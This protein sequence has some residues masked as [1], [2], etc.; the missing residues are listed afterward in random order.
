MS[1][2]AVESRRTD[3]GEAVA[4]D[5]FGAAAPV[6][7]KLLGRRP[8][9]PV[10]SRLRRASSSLPMQARAAASACAMRALARQA[11]SSSTSLRRRSVYRCTNGRRAAKEEGELA[12]EVSITDLGFPPDTALAAGSR[13]C[14]SM[15]RAIVRS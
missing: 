6:L 10:L 3:I 4:R 2:D 1:R 15:S 14:T 12:E 11:T 13:I 5:C 8:S 9:T 7:D